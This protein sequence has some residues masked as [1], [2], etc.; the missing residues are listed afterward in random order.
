MVTIWCRRLLTSAV[1]S[2]QS[3]K[4][5]LYPV[6]YRLL[7]QG[8][9][10]DRMVQVGKCVT[11]IYY[12]MEPAGKKRLKEPIQEYEDVTQGLFQITREAGG[13]HEQF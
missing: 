2:S 11:S 5:P 1:E 8:F 4:A 6:L 10:S 3:R 12:R 9:I 13:T 7:D